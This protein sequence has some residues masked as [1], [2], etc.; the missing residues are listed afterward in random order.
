MCLIGFTKTN[1]NTSKSFQLV[2]NNWDHERACKTALKTRTVDYIL[3]IDRLYIL[4]TWITSDGRRR[5]SGGANVH[6]FTLTERQKP[7]I[8]KE[9]SN[10]KREYMNISPPPT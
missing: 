1:F 7:S 3:Y 10:G 9:T 8:S 5:L 2:S 4:Q 6:I